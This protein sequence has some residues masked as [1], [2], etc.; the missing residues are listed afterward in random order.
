MVRVILMVNP[1]IAIPRT[2]A[3]I[4]NISRLPIGSS[5]NRMSVMGGI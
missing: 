1:D 2:I 5:V 3:G 4:M